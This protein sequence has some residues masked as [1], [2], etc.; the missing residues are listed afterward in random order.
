MSKLS[1]RRK[2]VPSSDVSFTKY[3]KDLIFGKDKHESV[4]YQYQEVHGSHKRRERSR[5]RRSEQARLSENPMNQY[6]YEALPPVIKEKTT[7]E[8][9]TRAKSVGPYR[10]VAYEHADAR[11]SARKGLGHRRIASTVEDA[12][13]EYIDDDSRDEEAKAYEIYQAY[14]SEGLPP[15]KNK[16]AGHITYARGRAGHAEDDDYERFRDS[17]STLHKVRRDSVL[18][19]PPPMGPQTH[20]HEYAEPAKPTIKREP[21]EVIVTTERYVYNKKDDKASLPVEYAKPSDRR[22]HERISSISSKNSQK[23]VAY[24]PA[25]TYQE[26]WIGKHAALPLRIDN[27]HARHHDAYDHES[28]TPVAGSFVDAE[29]MQREINGKILP[30][31]LY[32]QT[33]D[34]FAERQ[35]R[36]S[37]RQAA[38]QK[39]VRRHVEAP[40]ITSYE[41]GDTYYTNTQSYSSRDTAGSSPAN[42][43]NIYAPRRREP[44][45][46]QRMDSSP[47]HL[48]GEYHSDYEGDESNLSNLKQDKYNHVKARLT[49]ER[50]NER[51]RARDL[52]DDSPQA[53]PRQAAS[54]YRRPSIR[55]MASFESDRAHVGTSPAH[56]RRREKE[57][58]TSS[59]EYDTDPAELTANDRIKCALG[60]AGAEILERIEV[61]RRERRVSFGQN[62][63]KTISRHSST[64]G[65]GTVRTDEARVGRRDGYGDEED[66]RRRMRREERREGEGRKMRERDDVRSLL[67]KEAE[68][69][70]FE[71]VLP[72]VMEKVFSGG[73]E[74]REVREREREGY[75]S[76]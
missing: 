8:R 57:R 65:T 63:Y 9:L 45:P 64:T 28:H 41:T 13:Q 43:R 51:I 42:N 27:R 26:E 35:H 74:R 40:S 54:N 76:H 36:N 22:G 4:E 56:P 53:P 73:R 30:S 24:E 60:K 17:S 15:H 5:E 37:L 49:R 47:R 10:N 46:I 19:M 14:M 48:P 58:Y 31:R 71:R 1:S 34:M 23:Y 7:T 66:R 55:P 72:R 50:K 20:Q 68:K 44:P 3:V 6:M 16:R 59:S 39:E 11:A 18:A 70:V 25:I 29:E 75:L 2:Q 67:E 33:T 61:P 32:R 62:E 69:V 38:A 21:D 52:E 12:D